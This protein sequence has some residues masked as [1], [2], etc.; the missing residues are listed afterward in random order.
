M[1]RTVRRVGLGSLVVL[2]LA[3]GLSACKAKQGRVCSVDC[4][5]LDPDGYTY[6]CDGNRI[7]TAVDEKKP[8]P[9]ADPCLVPNALPTPEAQ[10]AA[11]TALAA[12][13]CRWNSNTSLCAFDPEL[14]PVCLV[15][16]DCL[17]CKPS[18]TDTD[19]DCIPNALE[20]R[21]SPTNPDSD[22]DGVSDGCEDHNYNGVQDP[23]ELDPT[24][25]DTDGDCIPDGLEDANHNGLRDIGET[26][27]L[28]TDSD[29]DGIPDGTED[30]NCNGKVDPGTLTLGT[31]DKYGR[32][33]DVGCWDRTGEE[34]EMDPR[35]S[36]SDGDLIPD[37][38]ED[39]NKNGR[40]DP[41]ETC[42]AAPDSDCD[43]LPD[44]AEDKNQNGRVNSGE[45]DPLN[46]DTDGDCIKDGFEDKNHNGELDPGETS[47]LRSDSD[48]D[49]IPD[50]KEDR[51]CNG[52]VDTFFNVTDPTKSLDVNK[53]GCWDE[54]E[55][56]GETDPASSDSDGDGI[57][58]GVEDIDHDGFCKTEMLRDRHPGATALVRTLTESCAWLADSDCDGINDGKEDKNHSGGAPDPGE[59][60]P[61]NPD[62][63]YDG[64]P[65]G[66]IDPLQLAACEDKNND[67]SVDA[68]ETD[69][70]NYDSDFDGLGDG[71]EVT[72]V[73]GA[74]DPLNPDTDGDGAADGDE[75]K[76]FAVEQSVYPVMCQLD[77]GETDPRVA[78]LPP[79]L[80][81]IDNAKFQTCSASNLKELTYAETARPTINYR[82]AFEVESALVGSVKTN[83]TYIVAAF[84]KK[85]SAGTTPFRETDPGDTL[86][87]HVFES[88]K[89]IVQDSQTSQV[90]YRQVYGFIYATEDAG[91]LDDYLDGVRQKIA[92]EYD[93]ANVMELGSLTARPT[94]DSLSNFR[95][96]HAQR[97]LSVKIPSQ[98]TALKLRND[99][100]VTTVLGG[101]HPDPASVPPVADAVYASP[102]AYTTFTVYVGAA[103]RLDQ[104]GPTGKPV[105][106]LIVALTPDT[107]GLPAPE[108]RFY[109][110]RLTRLEDLTGGSALARYENQT[111]KNCESMNTAVAAADILWTVDDSASMQQMIK[112][113]Q[114]ASSDAR[115][116]L[117]ANSRN[118]DFRVTMTTTNNSRG[119]RYRCPPVGCNADCNDSVSPTATCA[120]ASGCLDK[121]VGCI[122]TC[123]AGGC[124][125]GTA[126]FFTCD[127]TGS[128]CTNQQANCMCNDGDLLATCASKAGARCLD[129]ADLSTG[130]GPSGDA[131][132]YPLPGGGGSFYY[133]DNLYLDCDDT[134]KGIDWCGNP[135]NG[136]VNASFYPGTGDK[137][138]ALNAST[139][140]FLGKGDPCVLAT[141]LEK[142]DLTGRAGT[143]GSCATNPDA[144]CERRTSETCA[145]GPQV[146]ASQMCDLIR[147]MGGLPTDANSNSGRPH[148]A[149]EM[150]TRTARE[151]VEAMLPALPKNYV[152]ATYKA[153][154]H[155]RLDCCS[156]CDPGD[157]TCRSTCCR[158]C[159]PTAC[160]LAN[161]NCCSHAALGL[162]CKIDAACEPC[163]PRNG[164]FCPLVPLVTIML[165]DEE[166]FWFKDECKQGY[167]STLGTY[168]PWQIETD[169]SPLAAGCRYADILADPTTLE[170]CSESYCAKFYTD[171]PR[172]YNPDLAAWLDSGGDYKLQPNCEDPL[173]QTLGTCPAGECVWDAVHSHCK[174]V[175]SSCSPYPEDAALSCNTDPCPQLLT[176]A[177]CE[178]TA[179]RG[180]CSWS[181]ASSKCSNVCAAHMLAG[182]TVTDKQTACSADP[183]C[184]WFVPFYKAVG[185]GTAATL[186]EPSACI[187]K[188]PLND[189]QACKRQRRATEAV[190]GELGDPTCGFG[191]QAE[192]GAHY[193]CAWVGGVCLQNIANPCAANTSA[194]NCMGELGCFWVD[195]SK[196]CK[197]TADCRNYADAPT[198]GSVFGCAWTGSCTFDARNICAA[199]TYNTQ[200]KCDATFMCHWASGACRAKPLA[201][202]GTVGPVYSI[203]RNKGNAGASN[204]GGMVS[205]DACA[206]GRLTWG[207]G[208]GTAYRD[209]AIAT[210]GRTQDVCAADYGYFMNLLVTDL[211]S[212]SRPYPL[213]GAP[214]AATLKVGIRRTTAVPIP[215]DNCVP[216]A[217]FDVPRSS[218]HG[219]VYDASR[220]T[221]AFKSDPVDGKG[222]PAD[223]TI[224]EGE[225]QFALA[226]DDLPKEGDILFV[227]YRTW[228]PVPCRGE[229]HASETC[230]RV[231]CQA[232][233]GACATDATCQ[234]IDWQMT[235]NGSSLCDY[236]C[237]AG[238]VVDRCIPSVTCAACQ[239]FDATL[240]KCVDL[241]G[242]GNSCACVGPNKT[243]CDP[244]GVSNC[245]LGMRCAEGSCTCESD[246]CTAIRGDGSFPVDKCTEVLG[247]CADWT[248]K[249]QQCNLVNAT[250]DLVA[251]QAGCVAAGASVCRWNIDTKICETVHPQCC[252]A[253]ETPMC[254]FDPERPVGQFLYCEPNCSCRGAP[255]ASTCDTQFTQLAC[256][257][258]LS[259]DGAVGCVWSAGV[260]TSPCQ[261]FQSCVGGYCD[262]PCGLNDRCATEV[263]CVCQPIGS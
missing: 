58:D 171:P 100:L 201:G 236:G 174:G 25:R 187:Y 30:R 48:G 215:P 97:Q 70:R 93:P 230:A 206:G 51:N 42:A 21:T 160:P 229:C 111:S 257:Q 222:G 240:S 14:P 202:L 95:I 216:Y 98:R 228:L 210:A 6:D 118:V 178:N 244:L 79:A 120:A 67:G 87:G 49:G 55:T 4:I 115:A 33:V 81:S 163:D 225:I 82:L 50:G 57:P 182:S 167:S 140:G 191:T 133:E 214:I 186:G 184:T 127:T 104:L 226:S 207:R 243:Y 195:A 71:C 197:Q 252:R 262:P 74:T 259:L 227:S 84:G 129:P 192:C 247:C 147:A 126:P 131:A 205:G 75:D 209:L 175:G 239:A 231:V 136:G 130:L 38:I 45:T 35:L 221:I 86:M 166:D 153:G 78:D 164:G 7:N 9:P 1:W 211:V 204:G 224:D 76:N 112:R 152:G 101:V 217:T 254:F 15:N 91:A 59:T 72:F 161:P 213:S 141:N 17:Q 132:A 102:R 114:Q 185:S 108:P 10:Q 113:L 128:G 3:C 234:A 248:L 85:N 31:I 162:N 47:P 116:T 149:P 189:C 256:E 194:A 121:H 44:G 169:I 29:G 177:D 5:C 83:A 24:N 263:G 208:D 233:T 80:C 196:T 99:L 96:L 18:D 144:C 258:T 12:Q 168:Y 172:G 122:Y 68:G 63:D 94:H 253:G 188:Y 150:G 22:G 242:A 26:S 200:A 34:P 151:L 109:A 103:Q 56:Q 255:C 170:P 179:L 154:E 156:T 173:N 261:G 11:C 159:D 180:Y 237:T 54:G 198:C 135:A 249:D 145:D 125:S 165:T 39:K 246:S 46:P 20:I 2:G 137:H 53:N 155:L 36:D 60:D 107:T 92:T 105:V 13:N 40:C 251:R 203:V 220:N 43:G 77:A 158:T 139:R 88:P 238:A 218:T 157:P 148:S 232:P 123:P 183:L 90:V 37:R 52:L 219:F 28:S 260:C 110:D 119:A 16:C 245:P 41:G 23:G 61:R 134:K 142:L 8:E 69:P 106:L 89:G 241:P 62:S 250:V 212:L 199:A 19:G 64:L 117:T 32:L 193:G 124:Y 190:R 235:C 176:L 181:L 66:C 138:V 143:A 65:D 223:G 27:A 73:G 146:L